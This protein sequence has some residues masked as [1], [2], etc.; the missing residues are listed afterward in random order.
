MDL[1]CGV[2]TLNILGDVTGGLDETEPVFEA[3][4]L[5]VEFVPLC[6]ILS[7]G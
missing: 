4:G 2:G 3:L 5:I 7:N 1:G 6:L